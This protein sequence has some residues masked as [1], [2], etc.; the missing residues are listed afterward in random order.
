MGVKGLYH[1]I[2]PFQ[3]PIVIDSSQNIGIDAS[4]LLYSFR[5]KF[6]EI[7]KSL[8]ELNSKNLI[9][10]FDGKPPESK[11]AE[12]LIRKETRN[13][14]AKRIAN[15]NESLNQDL[16]PE[17]RLLIESRIRSLEYI[18]WNLTYEIKNNFKKELNERGI[19]YIKSN[20]EADTVLI[21]L[22]YGKKIDII[23]SSDMDYL[24][25]G[26]RNLWI[27]YRGTYKSIDLHTLLEFEDINAEQ[28][29]EAAILAGIDNIKIIE[30]LDVGTAMGWIRYYGSI[31][32]MM[33][34]TAHQFKL[35]YDT[36]IYE[37]KK[38]YNPNKDIYLHIKEE[39]IYKLNGSNNNY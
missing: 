11:N 37:V 9:F 10:V 24:V 19:L 22:Y 17:T 34:R 21:D 25:A 13:L 16:N 32:Y 1:Y 8:E 26:V 14:S 2:K 35:P 6:D 30:C 4:S 15:L 12:L 36:Y 23:I 31:Y 5:G 20:V 29:K 38:R 28:F 33:T 7:F 27:P 3:R 39:H 18:G